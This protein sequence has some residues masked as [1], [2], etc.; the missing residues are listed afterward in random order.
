MVFQP[1]QLYHIYNRSINKQL[2]FYNR[3]NYLFFL[4][5]VRHQLISHCDF[6]AYCLMPNHFHFLISTRDNLEEYKF[7]NA[8][9]SLLR[10][11]T[12]AINKQ[13]KRTGSLF[14]QHTKAKCLS[15]ENLSHS[16]ALSH[17]MASVE[18][19]F[20]CF[21]YIHQNPMAAGLVN[22]MEDWEFSSFRD[23]VNFRDGT[24]CNKELAIEL[25]DLDSD[26]NN[27][28]SDSYKVIYSKK[29]KNIFYHPA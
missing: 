6:L 28:Y 16:M 7:R 27:F 29:I 17:T 5:K 12:Q 1:N 13:E 19:A 4:K 15:E 24:L 22:K 14:Q 21:N 20:V 26:R 10:S 18:Y 9:G 11:Y 2:L 8:I 23:Y 25:L 3:E